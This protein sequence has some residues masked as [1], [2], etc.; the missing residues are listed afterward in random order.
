[1][2]ERNVRRDD[3]LDPVLAVVHESAFAALLPGNI[4]RFKSVRVDGDIR[5]DPLCEQAVD[6]AIV[7]AVDREVNIAGIRTRIAEFLIPLD[8]GGDADL[9]AVQAGLNLQRLF[10][11]IGEQGAVVVDGRARHCSRMIGSDQPAFDDRVLPFVGSAGDFKISG[12]FCEQIVAGRG[13][14]D[15]CLYRVFAGVCRADA[16]RRS[17]I[18]TAVA[19]ARIRICDAERNGIIRIDRKGL[20]R[21]IVYEVIPFRFARAAVL[22]AEGENLLA[23]YEVRGAFV[24]VRI[25]AVLLLLAEEGDGIVP[26][27]FAVA[28]PMH[29]SDMIGAGVGDVRNFRTVRCEDGEAPDLRGVVALEQAVVTFAGFERKG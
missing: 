19:L 5:F 20:A 21:I 1:M 4:I 8:A 24:G 3:V 11:R 13:L 6:K 9:H 23:D 7:A 15:G 16:C 29:A 14:V 12:R 2:V 22:P 27:E 18:H 28:V 10:E 26:A 17:V 25:A